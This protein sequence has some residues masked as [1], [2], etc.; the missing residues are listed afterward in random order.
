L[1]ESMAEYL[2]TQMENELAAKTVALKV[3]LMDL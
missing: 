1:V 3:A 2:V